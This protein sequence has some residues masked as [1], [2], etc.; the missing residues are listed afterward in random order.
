MAPA[1]SV[2]R[3]R[4]CEGSQFRRTHLAISSSVR[5]GVVVVAPSC[6]SRKV[7]V[8]LR[9]CAIPAFKYPLVPIPHSS[10]RFCP[11]CRGR[12]SCL[13]LKTI[14]PRPT[15]LARSPLS[16][17]NSQTRSISLSDCW[18]VFSEWKMR[19]R[20]NLQFVVCLFPVSQS[21]AW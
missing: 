3:R 5:R 15:S 12:L 18:R 14:C 9:C 7:R 8:A 1:R 20:R 19:S 10:L 16:P 21:L 17:S 4:R 11:Q 6:S 13:V 2:N